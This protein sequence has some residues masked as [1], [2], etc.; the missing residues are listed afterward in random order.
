MDGIEALETIHVWHT[1]VAE[2]QLEHAIASF[3]A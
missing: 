1:V 2:D 3:G